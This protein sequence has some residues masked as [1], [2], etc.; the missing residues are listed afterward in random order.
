MPRGIKIPKLSQAVLDARARR[1]QVGSARDVKLQ[2]FIREVSDKVAMPM[3]GRV[4]MATTFLKD[5]VV[6]NISTPVIKARGPRGGKVILGRSKSGGFPHADTTQLMKTIFSHVVQTKKGLWDGFVGTPLDYG[7]IL[8]TKMN[9]SF[10]RRTL[11]EQR[12]TIMAIL[13][14]PIRT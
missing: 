9:R 1:V 10:L 5:K 3:R 7:V 13:S 14:G 8:E 12:S 11:N 4:M 2:W 6:R